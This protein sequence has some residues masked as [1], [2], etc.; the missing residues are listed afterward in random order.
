MIVEARRGD[1]KARNANNL[2]KICISRGNG[3]AW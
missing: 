2:R 1:T 3:N